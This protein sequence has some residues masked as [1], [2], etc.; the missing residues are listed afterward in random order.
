MAYDTL[1]KWRNLGF[2][3]EP[4][5]PAASADE[6]CA[7]LDPL[8][9]INDKA[10]VV[11]LCTCNGGTNG[12]VFLARSPV[13]FSMPRSQF[14]TGQAVRRIPRSDQSEKEAVRERDLA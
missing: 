3:V 14:L 6:G 8:R 5:D 4:L 9:T 1:H 11:M 12:F 10:G 2:A 13:V 7:K